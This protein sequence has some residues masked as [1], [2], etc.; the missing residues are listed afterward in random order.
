MSV[1][2]LYC[3]MDISNRRFLMK[4]RPENLPGPQHYEIQ[5][6]PVPPLMPD[7]VV[8]KT[9]LVALSPWQGQRSK[10]FKNYARPFD[11]GELIDCDVLGEVV[12]SRCDEV[13]VGQRVTARLG[14]Q[15]YAVASKDQ[16]KPI[17]NEFADSHWLTALSSPGQTA[18]LAM[19][20]FAWP[21][22]GQTVVVTS[23]AGAVGCYAVQ[24]ARNAGARVIGITGSTDKCETIVNQ[25]GADVALSF[26]TPDFADELAKACSNG[27][28]MV[29]DTTGGPVTDQIFEH[30]NK[31]AVVLMVGRTVANNS[32]TPGT[33]MVNMRQLW[34]REAKIHTFSRYSYASQWSSA[35]Q[36]LGKLLATGEIKAI[37]NIVDGFENTPQAL[38]DM[39]AGNYFGKVLVRYAHPQETKV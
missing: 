32:E 2:R 31:H 7:Q 5:K 17:S 10:D 15:E 34:A 8:V 24:L 21:T 19:D 29:F 18:Y 4:A 25:L 12:Q 37:E 14:W 27:V 23:A 22:P 39:L 9:E 38:H 36:A 13:P 6:L 33:D 28:D 20:T 30:V 35:Q 3:V 26:R 1:N 11:I 16:L